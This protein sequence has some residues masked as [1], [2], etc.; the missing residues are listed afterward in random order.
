MEQNEFQD[1]IL[2]EESSPKSS[3][4]VPYII[5][6]YKSTCQHTGDDKTFPVI[7]KCVSYR[8]VADVLIFL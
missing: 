7:L 4:E 6:P 8:N 5:M 2:K 3:A 1:T